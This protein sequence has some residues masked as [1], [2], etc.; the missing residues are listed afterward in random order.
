MVVV[1][2]FVLKEIQQIG[3]IPPT[4]SN[5]P[6]GGADW[7]CSTAFSATRTRKFR[8]HDGDFPKNLEVDTKL[9]HLAHNSTPGFTPTIKPGP[10]RR[11]AKD[12]AT[13]N[14]MRFA[15]MPQG[16]L[17]P[18][19]T[20]QRENRARRQDKGQGLGYLP[21]APWLSSTTAS[22][23]SASRSRCRSRPS[24]KP[25]RAFI[26]FAEIAVPTV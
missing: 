18:G 24:S 5:A 17:L 6:R 26:V 3:A 8:I 14:S 11:V 25:A 19:E 20:L 23:T 15:Q 13:F 9:I 12:S 22:R 2:R 7:K 21:T 4:P 10:D 16:D 1:P